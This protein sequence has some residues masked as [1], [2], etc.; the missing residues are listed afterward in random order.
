MDL[1]LL[2][3]SYEYTRHKYP[4]PGV[5]YPRS[6]R[7]VHIVAK[8]EHGKTHILVVEDWSP[9]CY[10]PLDLP[11]SYNP[12]TRNSI[13]HDLQKDQFQDADLTGSEIVSLKQF[14]GF[15]NLQQKYYAK[16]RFTDWRPDDPESKLMETSVKPEHKFFHETK[17]RSGAWFKVAGAKATSEHTNDAPLR[18]YLCDLTACPQD[19]RPPTLTV[20]AYDLETTGLD[21]ATCS[22]H[23]VC[24]IFWTTGTA[25]PE[26]GADPRSVVICS[27]PTTSVNGT[28]VVVVK[29]EEA[30]L[31]EMRDHILRYD[32]DLLCG[33]NLQFDNSMIMERSKRISGCHDKFVVLGRIGNCK[34]RFSVSTFTSAAL[35]TNERVLWQIPGR[36]V[37][38]LYSY[39]KTN[40]PSL[41]SYKLDLVGKQ[42]VDAGKVRSC[43]DHC[44]SA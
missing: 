26:T 16:L 3:A 12:Q 5:K 17:L 39:C 42:F 25:V 31:I 34:S 7:R 2:H 28:R 6:K 29:G 23:Q 1:F 44:Q 36:W 4:V 30:L 43:F 9:Y 37:M 18:C 38:D 8:D 13:L 21:P 14:V 27:Q 20:C 19:S 24:L 11:D 22:I 40:F 33:Y 10:Y 41:P 35:G 15:T 32:P